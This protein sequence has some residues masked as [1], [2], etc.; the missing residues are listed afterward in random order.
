WDEDTSVVTPNEDVFYLVAL[1]RSALQ[2]GDEALTLER[3]SDEN[4]QILNFC[5]EQNIGVKQYLPH[6]TTQ[7]EWMDHYGEKWPQIYKRKMEFDP[8][9][10]LATGQ[11][12]FQPSF[13]SMMRSW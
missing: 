10:I 13:T 7:Q 11:K 6:Y 3:L 2:N 1:L 9:H 5:K 4:R 12:I 8:R